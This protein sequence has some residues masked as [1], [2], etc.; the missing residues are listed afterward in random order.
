[1]VCVVGKVE[2]LVGV[3]VVGLVEVGFFREIVKRKKKKEKTKKEKS[4]KKNE[5]STGFLVVLL[6][7]YFLNVFNSFLG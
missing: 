5:L 1:M 4:Q 6:F 3:V 2:R 7:Y